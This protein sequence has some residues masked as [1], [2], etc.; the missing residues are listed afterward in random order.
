[1]AA[2]FAILEMLLKGLVMKASCTVSSA[3][4]RFW[5]MAKAIGSRCMDLHQLPESLPVACPG[6]ANQ[7]YFF[8]EEVLVQQPKKTLLLRLYASA[9]SNRKCVSRIGR[10]GVLYIPNFSA[11][12]SLY[13]IEGQIFVIREVRASDDKLN[14]VRQAASL[15]TLTKKWAKI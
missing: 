1:M 2:I 6:P 10:S 8:M 5:R 15:S 3:S 13:I 7:G 9:E 11:F 12:H 14:V 4:L